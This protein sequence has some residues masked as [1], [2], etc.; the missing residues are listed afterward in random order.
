MCFLIFLNSS[1]IKKIF[2]T[3]FLFF[4][5][6]PF[7]FAA[8][9]LQEIMYNPDGSD[10]NREWIEILNDGPAVDI[11]SWYL[12]E[13][14]TYHGLYPDGFTILNR[15][16]RALI[17]KDV[18]TARAELGSQRF[19]KA[20]FSLNNTGETLVIADDQ[21]NHIDTV[22]YSSNMGAN[23]DGKSLQFF[24]SSWIAATPTPGLANSN[25]DSS[26]GG[27]GDDSQGEST[28]NEDT[29]TNTVQTIDPF[30]TAQLSVPSVILA[31]SD[32]R[33]QADVFYTN[34][35]K[36]MSR[37]LDG[38]YYLNF[39]NGDVFISN[40]RID[41]NYRYRIPGDYIISFEYY[42]S[43]LAFD[44]GEEPDAFVQKTIHV[45]EHSIDILS[46]DAF[47]GVVLKNNTSQTVQLDG[48]KIVWNKHVYTFP[49]RSYLAGG[50]TMPVLFRTLGFY[51]QASVQYPISLLSNA[52]KPITFFPKKRTFVSKKENISSKNIQSSTQHIAGTQKNIV[53]T[54]KGKETNQNISVDFDQL[55]DATKNN[56]FND[57]DSYLNRY[58]ANN[59][60]KIQVDF[61]DQD[62]LSN[63]EKHKETSQNSLLYVLGSFVVMLGAGRFIKH[64]HQQKNNEEKEPED[65]GSIEVIE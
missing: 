15:G 40:K 37:K 35:K 55:P 54:V 21:K 59:P 43:K 13:N 24:Q 51:P 62:T 44:V 16:E 57:N 29:T 48:W 32:F 38:Y 25:D 47:Q 46:A 30:Y 53:S 33:I 58:L 26:Q 19:I 4:L 9:S 31:Q 3:I 5:Y 45:T 27:G 2:I 6:S 28:N 34:E 7:V 1:M 41:R 18:A 42:H 8:V 64:K 56:F 49:R 10:T 39:G 22:N 60:G 50:N 14:D 23:G 36:K 17:V 11:S 12:N 65:L 63:I 61:H 20:S 52:S